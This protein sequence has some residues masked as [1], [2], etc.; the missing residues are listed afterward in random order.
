VLPDDLPHVGRA[1]AVGDFDIADAGAKKR[2]L[3]LA[4]RPYPQL[5]ETLRTTL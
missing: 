3:K 4:Q 5:I 2:A 1:G